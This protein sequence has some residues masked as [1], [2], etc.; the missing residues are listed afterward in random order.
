VKALGPLSQLEALVQRGR[1]Y[2]SLANATRKAFKTL[3]WQLLNLQLQSWR[4]LQ[5]T[6]SM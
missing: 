2:L 4:R 3:S 6:A 5:S 1:I